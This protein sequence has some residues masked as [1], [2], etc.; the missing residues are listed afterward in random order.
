M[1]PA[2]CDTPC[3]DA[4]VKKNVKIKRYQ[5]SDW[6]YNRSGKDLRLRRTVSAPR[7]R[8]VSIRISSVSPLTGG[9]W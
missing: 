3:T 5:Y 1:G 7:R 2:S 6:R 9:L 8:E 4:S